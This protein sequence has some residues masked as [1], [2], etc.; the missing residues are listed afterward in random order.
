MQI[1]ELNNKIIII[2]DS[3]KK[4]LLK[5]INDSKKLLNIKIITLSELLKKYYF[6]YSKETIYYVCKKYNVVYDVAKIY[7]DNLYYISEDSDNEKIH[8]LYNLKN[9]LSNNGLIKINKLFR[10][11]LKNKD[12]VL[13]NLKYIDKL[14]LNIINELKEISNIFEFNNEYNSSKKIVY[15]ANDQEEEILFVASSIC[16]LISKGI[17]INNIKLANVN[18]DYF[19]IIKKIFKLFNIPINLK[20]KYSINGTYIVKKFKELYSSDMNIVFDELNKFVKTNEE[21]EIYK[22]LVNIVNNYSFINDFNEVKELIYHDIDNTYIKTKKL[23]NAV[24]TISFDDVAS[25]NEYVFLINFNEGIIP[26]NHKDED[27]LNDKIKKELNI[28]TSYELNNDNTLNIQD[29]IKYSNN[30]VITYTKHIN[31][32]EVYKSS[33]YSN[34]LMDIKNININFNYS[35][36]YNKLKLVSL[37]DEN[38]KFGTISEELIILNSMYKDEK[39][40]NYDNKYKMID[41]DKL[42]EYLGNKLILSYTSINDFYKCKFRYYLTHILK[43]NKYEDSYEKIIGKIFHKILSE[44]FVDDYDL[45]S[46][47]DE[48]VQSYNY[49]F[50]NTEKFFI[51]KLKDELKV[52]VD[53]IKTQLNYTR[54]NKTMYEKEIIININEELHITFK[55]VIDKLMYD[56][57][58]GETIVVIIDY[59]T[60]TP[61]LNLDNTIYGL[62]LQLPVYIY[63]T[64]NMNEITNVRIGGF[65]LQK[66]LT[67]KLDNDDKIRELKLQGYSN[68]D[69]NILSLVD[70]SYEN[71]SIIKSMKVTST[72]N[73]NQ[74]AKVISDEEIDELSIL[75][76]TKI[77]EASNDIINASFDINPKQI[78]NDLVGCK[79]CEF[80]NICYMK[81][82]DIIKLKEEGGE[83]NE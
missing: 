36:A 37:K 80:K 78:K 4:T 44:C 33:A 19:F 76:E 41:K 81:N 9:E 77:K 6:D 71:S 73:F 83:G 21:K 22:N 74:F 35:N 29:N 58:N 11:F 57:Y 61:Y 1:E 66:L 56:E 54:L 47:Y 32:I 82:K 18:D 72:G 15:E 67:N 42:Y 40:L 64:K 38:N 23:K 43:I 5:K 17:D 10:E 7:I 34:Y 45:D 30:L 62:E 12:I 8:F 51:N 59:K 14:F 55:G 46:R 26:I 70:S 13:Y 48:E 31:G 79:F 68:S 49:E 53:T 60:G 20:S 52:I 27:F 25:D 24:N 50:N 69:I 3:Y 39:Y 75:A 2:K 63:L 16:E 28:S 65:Y